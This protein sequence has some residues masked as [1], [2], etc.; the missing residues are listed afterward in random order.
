MADRMK[1]KRVL[2][3]GAGT[4]IGRGTALTFAE[5]GADVA[6]HYSHSDQGAKDAVAQIQAGG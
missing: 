6:L 4:G 3:T 2:V 5:E 1:G